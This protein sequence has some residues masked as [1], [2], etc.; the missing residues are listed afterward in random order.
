[1]LRKENL[2]L[3]LLAT[4]VAMGV[5]SLFFRQAPPATQ[6]GGVVVVS[7]APSPTLV[8]TTPPVAVD[9]PVLAGLQGKVLPSLDC[10]YKWQDPVTVTVPDGWYADA[11]LTDIG[12][13]EYGIDAGRTVTTV[14]ATLKVVR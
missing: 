1:M 2:T 12:R 10:K 13:A 4:L 14:E 11:W 5:Y 7:P 9:C 8:P 3:L 6:A